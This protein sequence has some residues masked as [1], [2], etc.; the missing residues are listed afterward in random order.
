MQ[1]SA[2]IGRNMNINGIYLPANAALVEGSTRFLSF[3]DCA[4]TLSSPM[5][6]LFQAQLV[7][8]NL[9]IFFVLY[10]SKGDARDDGKENATGQKARH[11]LC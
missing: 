3:T 9:T 2:E 1:L 11:N 4:S 6:P 5:G 8:N 7:N 10:S